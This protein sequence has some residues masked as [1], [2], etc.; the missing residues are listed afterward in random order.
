M[1]RLPHLCHPIRRHYRT[2]LAV[3]LAVTGVGAWFASKLKIDTDL[4]ALLPDSFH[5]VQALKRMEGEVGG[6]SQ[7]RVALSSDDFE[8]LV[9]LADHLAV[10]LTESEYV[11]SV[12]YQN[13]VDFYQRHALLFLDAEELDSLYDAVEGAIEKERQAVN[14]FMVD[15]LFGPPPP[16][17]EDGNDLDAWE[18]RYTAELPTRHYLNEDSTV[19]VLNLNPAQEGANIGYGRR[20]LADVR[21]VMDEV[22]PASFAPDMEV[23]YGGNVKNRIDELEAI[24]AD[25]LGTAGLGVTG[26]FLLL[27]AFYRRFVVPVLLTVTLLMSLAWTFGLTFLLIGQL[28]TITAFLF[29]VLFGMGIDVGI[30]GASRYLESR[31]AGLDPEGSLHRMVCMTG[32]AQATAAAT[33]SAAFFILMFLDFR[34]FSELGLIVGIGLV[35]SWFAMVVVLPAMFVAAEKMGLMQVRPVPGRTLTGD[36]QPLLGARGIVAGAAVATLALT[37][38]FTQVSFQYDFT[39]LR[40]ITNEREEYARVTAGVFTRSESPA[41]VIADTPEEVEE[42]VEAVEEIIRADTVSPT[43][44][45]VRSLLSVVPAG[46][47][48]KIERIRELRA[49]VEEEALDVV[50]GKDRERVEALMAFL[51]V[52]EPFGWDDFPVKDRGQF[53]NRKG[54]PGNFVLI[55]P[56]VAL[57]DGRN[58]MAFRDDIG[59]IVTPSGKEYHAGS[60]NLIVADMLTMIGREGPIAAVMALS[61]VFLILF[62]D[63][64]SVRAA[65][66]VMTPVVVGVLWMGGLMKLF[67]MQLNFFNVVVFPSIIGIGDDAGVHIYHRYM[68]EGRRSLPFVMRRTGLAVTLT[69]VTTM[70]GYAGLLGAHHPGLQSI[71]YLALIGLSTTLLTAYFVLPALLE[72]FDRRRGALGGGGEVRYR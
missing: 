20:M 38:L 27:V 45:S 66:F 42:V 67:G 30:H 48:E 31:Q 56:S 12:D 23:V 19:L 6:T 40:I 64:R 37:Y 10:A 2:I 65:L 13:D 29:V 47:V 28:N 70:V 58:A 33:T 4:A 36:P 50:E 11:G 17:G 1:P 43:V 39:N 21:R 25:V 18:E 35:L 41:I 8:A 34:G 49:L 62:L 22:R 57:R 26:V 46:Q 5:S 61:M 59:T 9:R 51:A 53:S 54:E 69:T 15:D 60:S 52:D 32:A 3:S 14:P 7:L 72:V 44:A 24:S 63:F 71:G 68:E 16:A 55:Y